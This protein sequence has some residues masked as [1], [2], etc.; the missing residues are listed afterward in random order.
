MPIAYVDA[1]DFDA[2]CDSNV[3]QSLF[4]D[5]DDSG[6]EYATRFGRAAEIASSLALSSAKQAGYSPAE[7]TTD[8]TVKALA[9]S[10]LV[11][12]AYGRKARDIPPSIAAILAPIPEGVRSGELPLAFTSVSST[13][14]ATGGSKFTPTEETVTVGTTSRK[15][16]R[17]PVMRNLANLV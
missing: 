8:D 13:S 3:R 11:H 2:V 16:L 7:N 17:N 12:M 5:N 15:I 14:E 9:L 4:T 1:D 6:S 10:F